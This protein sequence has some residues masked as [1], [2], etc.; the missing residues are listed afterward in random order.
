MNRSEAIRTAVGLTFGLARIQGVADADERLCG[1][2]RPYWGAKADV[3]QDMAGDLVDYLVEGGRDTSPLNCGHQASELVCFT[4]VGAFLGAAS[5]KGQRGVIDHGH[6]T[7]DCSHVVSSDGCAVGDVGD[8][9][10]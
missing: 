9:Q 1:D 10:S 3:L 8:V 2:S 6:T 7:S 5:E 4:C